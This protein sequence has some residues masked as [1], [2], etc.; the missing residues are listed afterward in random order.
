M[1]HV[2]LI[3]YRFFSLSKANQSGLINPD[4]DVTASTSGTATVTK[5]YQVVGTLPKTPGAGSV[6]IKGA[7]TTT[8]TNKDSVLLPGKV[9]IELTKEQQKAIDKDRRDKDLMAKYAEG[10]IDA[11]DID[12]SSNSSSNQ[13]SVQS[14]DSNDPRFVGEKK[15]S[16]IEDL[17]GRIEVINYHY[18]LHTLGLYGM[19]T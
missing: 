11:P 3:S 13:G 19:D 15:L 12:L 10:L 14:Q 8:V 7:S 4:M 9:A 1:V 5:E 6:Q 18:L 17:K 16:M 2:E